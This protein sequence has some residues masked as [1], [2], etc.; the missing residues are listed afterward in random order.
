[1]AHQNTSVKAYAKENLWH[2]FVFWEVGERVSVLLGFLIAAGLAGLSLY[3]I[4]VVIEADTIQWFIVGFGFWF[5]FLVLVV[6]HYRLW[7]DQR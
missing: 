6:T 4:S 3:G 1:M 5:L 7:A 2:S